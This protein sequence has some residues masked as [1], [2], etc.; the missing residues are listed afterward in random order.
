MCVS[1]NKRR[2][3]R[4]LCNFLHNPCSHWSLKRSS[5]VTDLHRT[6][7]WFVNWNYRNHGF[8]HTFL[9]IFTGRESHLLN[10]Q[11]DCQTSIESFISL[12][13][14]AKLLH[15]EHFY[16]TEHTSLSQ[17]LTTTLLLQVLTCSNL[18]D[19]SKQ[20]WIN[21]CLS[22]DLYHSNNPLQRMRMWCSFQ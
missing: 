1:R 9:Q 7:I 13:V 6:T 21:S 12:P 5:K 22:S 20:R 8:L 14:Y 15:T 2:P 19:C 10:I 16:L 11:L 18:V 3:S 4:S 17:S